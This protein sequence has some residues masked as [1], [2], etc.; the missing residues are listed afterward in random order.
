M[1]CAVRSAAAGWLMRWLVVVGCC[2][3]PS[4]APYPYPAQPWLAWHGMAAGS[5]GRHSQY[6]CSAFRFF[7]CSDV[8]TRLQDRCTRRGCVCGRKLSED[9]EEQQ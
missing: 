5:Q 4:G 2:D 9:R 1:Q 7:T 8:Q 6:N 3:V